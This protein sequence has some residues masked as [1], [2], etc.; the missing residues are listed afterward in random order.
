MKAADVIREVKKPGKVFAGVL[1]SNDV[2][3]IAVE[4]ADLLRWLQYRLADED[5]GMSASVGP[6][7]AVYIDN[8]I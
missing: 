5:C 2:A 3:Y 6:D 7:G 1:I 8:S 4:K